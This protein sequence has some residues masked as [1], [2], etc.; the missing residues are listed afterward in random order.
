M[1]LNENKVLVSI[2]NYIQ[3]MDMIFNGINVSEDR[4]EK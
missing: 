4:Y 2:S 1:K 3:G